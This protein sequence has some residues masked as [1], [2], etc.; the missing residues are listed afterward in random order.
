ML[1]NK[2]RGMVAFGHQVESRNGWLQVHSTTLRLFTWGPT[3]LSTALVVCPQKPRYLTM[4][5]YLLHNL[6]EGIA[7]CGHCTVRHQRR[8]FVSYLSVLSLF[9]FCCTYLCRI[10]HKASEGK[11]YTQARS[12]D[13]IAGPTSCTVFA[14]NAYRIV[15]ACLRQCD[16]RRSRNA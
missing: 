9:L 15:T 16:C 4:N 7:P 2:S 10:E 3:I 8:S 14:P 12:Q 13:E 11:S 1:P 6:E 5:T